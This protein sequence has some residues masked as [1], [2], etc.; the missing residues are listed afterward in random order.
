[1]AAAAPPEAERLSNFC[2]MKV[3]RIQVTASPPKKASQRPKGMASSGFIRAIVRNSRA[4]IASKNTNWVR[5]RA[6]ALS[7]SFRRAKT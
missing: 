7:S 3:V 1:M 5:P 6:V 4:G 2:E